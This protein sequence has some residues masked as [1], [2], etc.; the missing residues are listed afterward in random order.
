MFAAQMA[1][2]SP[3]FDGTGD[4]TIQSCTPLLSV[5]FWRH[6]LGRGAKY[7][8]TKRPVERPNGAQPVNSPNSDRGTLPAR[9]ACSGFPARRAT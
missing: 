9:G 5:F 3:P 1:Q 6:M 4:R 8:K 2:E 7:S